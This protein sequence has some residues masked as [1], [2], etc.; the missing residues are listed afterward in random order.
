MAMAKEIASTVPP[1]GIATLPPK[2][3]LKRA[4]FW[5]LVIP[6]KVTKPLPTR[7]IMEQFPQVTVSVNYTF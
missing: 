4:R 3:T 6:F 5:Q 7:W 2:L 1:V